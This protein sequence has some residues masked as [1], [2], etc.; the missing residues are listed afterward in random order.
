[1]SFRPVFF[2]LVAALLS[3]FFLARPV[4][5]EPTLT[6]L[7]QEVT[8]QLFKIS[9]SNTV[10]A[11][12]AP[13]WAKSYLESKGLVS[14]EIYPTTVENEFIVEGLNNGETVSIPISA[15]GSSTGFK[16]LLND[17]ANIAMSSR[18]IKDKENQLIDSEGRMVSF[19]AEHVVAIDGLAVIVHP[20]NPISELSVEEIAHI[21]AGN[22]QN[23]SQLGGP[24]LAIQP[25][26]RDDKSGTW[27]TFKNLVLQKRFK[28]KENTPRFES[29][30]LLSKKVSTIPGAIGFVGLASVLDS[31]PLAVSEDYTTPLLPHPLFVATEDYPLSRRLFMYTK[32]NETNFFVNEFLNFIQ[33]TNGQKTV[34]QVGFVSQM[35]VSIAAK[36]ADTLDAPESYIDLIRT[37]ERLS[38]NFRFQEGSA[39]L[40]NKAKRDV[41]RLV[42]YMRTPGNEQKSVQLIGFGDLKKSDQRS[43]VL[44]K[45]RALSVKFELQRYGISTEPVAG[46]GSYLPVASNLGQGKVKNQRVEVWLI[47]EDDNAN[48]PSQDNIAKTEKKKKSPDNFISLN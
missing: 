6:P 42:K 45:L 11:N 29:N 5:A 17:E 13:S 21:F 19:E 16:A 26:A 32:P 20:D 15:H 24:D 31:K 4:V 14:V 9:G 46:F 7:S 18:K 44:S 41:A 12:L 27:D 36:D 10:G 3:T 43:M 28:L 1:M 48:N 39:T 40:D 8:G 30:D 38:I 25:H 35:P 37:R 2:A 33:G 22:I 23:W 47:G 34:S